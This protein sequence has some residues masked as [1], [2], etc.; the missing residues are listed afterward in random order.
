MGVGQILWPTYGLPDEMYSAL[1]RSPEEVIREMRLAA[2]VEW[3]AQECISQGKDAAIAGL[4]R[5]EF[6]DELARRKIPVVQIRPEEV[7][8]EVHG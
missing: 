2:A 7:W 3:Y 5:A 8:Q 6:I 1:R 4:S